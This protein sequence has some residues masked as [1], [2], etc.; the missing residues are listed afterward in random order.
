MLL[1]IPHTI[2]CLMSSSC[3]RFE[4]RWGGS[5]AGHVGPFLLATGNNANAICANESVRCRSPLLLGRCCCQPVQVFPWPHDFLLCWKH[6][7]V[8]V[9]ARSSVKFLPTMFKPGLVAPCTLKKACGV[10]SLTRTNSLNKRLCG[11]GRQR[12][13]SLRPLQPPLSTSSVDWSCFW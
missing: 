4:R 6:C 5:G 9:H 7:V 2:Y 13:I 1:H 11:T 3:P 8:A 12:I 10:T